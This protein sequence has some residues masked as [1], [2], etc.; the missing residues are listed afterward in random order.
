[1]VPVVVVRLVERRVVPERY[2]LTGTEIPGGRGWGEL[3][4][5]LPC[6]HQND[7]VLRRAGV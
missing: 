4:L 2:K 7:F 6:H 3:Y 5:T 1:M